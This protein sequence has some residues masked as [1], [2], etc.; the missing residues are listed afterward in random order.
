MSAFI[1]SQASVTDSDGYAEYAQSVPPTLGGYGGTILTKG[2]TGS[3]LSGENCV[4]HS[5][6]LQFP[7]LEKAQSWYH[8]D[9]YQA[10]GVCRT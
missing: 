10:L 9:P 6:V 8:S 4:T 2:K 3:V 1:I 5:A 7:D